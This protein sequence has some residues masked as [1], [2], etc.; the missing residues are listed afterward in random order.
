[1]NY[2]DIYKHLFTAMKQAGIVALAL[3]SEIINEGKEVE[4][5]TAESAHHKAMRTA[6]TKVDELVQEML[7]QALLPEYATLLSLDVEEETDT[8]MR[9]TREDY[10]YT[11]VLDPIDGTLEYINQKDTYSIC[12]A[13]LYE[14]DVKVAL[15]YFPKRN[16]LYGYEETMGSV[17]Y[18]KLEDCRWNDYQKL[19]YQPKNSNIVYKN[20]RL[21]K[22]ISE[23]LEQVGYLVIDDNENGLTCPDALIECM[24]GNAVAYFSDTRNIRD[25]LLGAVIEKMKTGHAY[26]FTGDKAKWNMHGRQ[27]EIVFTIYDKKNIF[28]KI[29]K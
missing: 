22:C 11:L 20:S 16:I 8:K 6:K 4:H 26:T 21:D 13:L 1:M 27:K 15:V 29:V 9:Y 17:V 5:I 23:R 25:I 19:D 24:K 14:H 7:L 18:T 12:A 2:L 3:Q 10:K 28:E